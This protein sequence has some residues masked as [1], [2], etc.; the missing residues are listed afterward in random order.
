MAYRT[1]IALATLV[2]GIGLA[3]G[4]SGPVLAQNSKPLSD[5]IDARAAEN[6]IA[7][8]QETHETHEWTIGCGIHLPEAGKAPC[9]FSFT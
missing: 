6:A 4:P 5:L 7:Y 9:H 3:L 1:K 2:A 8:G